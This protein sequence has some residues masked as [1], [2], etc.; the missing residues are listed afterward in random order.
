MQCINLIKNKKLCNN[1][2]LFND[3]LAEN[4]EMTN[5]TKVTYR[6]FINNYSLSIHEVAEVYLAYLYNYALE[7][8]TQEKEAQEAR[9]EAKE[10]RKEAKEK[11]EELQRSQE[12]DRQQREDAE[13]SRQKMLSKFMNHFNPKTAP[14]VLPNGSIDVDSILKTCQYYTLEGYKKG[15]GYMEQYLNISKYFCE[16]NYLSMLEN[17]I[18]MHQYSRPD[19]VTGETNIKNFAEILKIKGSTVSGVAIALINY[20]IHQRWVPYY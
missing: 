17:E 16:E 14:A 4:A 3:F 15:L 10:A 5:I 2:S 6:R 18:K 7:V 9:K 8:I 12:K 19:S 11:A 1:S 13:R 20:L